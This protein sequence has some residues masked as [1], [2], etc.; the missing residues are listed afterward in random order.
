V[1]LHIDPVPDIEPVPVDRKL[2]VHM[3]LRS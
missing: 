2:F 1:I 3:A